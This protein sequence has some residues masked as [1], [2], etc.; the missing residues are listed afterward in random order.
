ML[1]REVQ[2]EG[3]HRQNQV[4]RAIVGLSSER[5]DINPQVEISHIMP[6]NPLSLD[7]IGKNQTHATVLKHSFVL[8]LHPE[9]GDMHYVQ[10]MSVF[11]LLL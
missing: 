11:L 4:P 5:W 10:Y 6:V 7:R 9:S 1:G 3:P 2:G 8:I